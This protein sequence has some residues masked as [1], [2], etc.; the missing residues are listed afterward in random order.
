M[1]GK[2]LAATAERVEIANFF[3]Y[4]SSF[5][6]GIYVDAGDYNND[7]FADILTGPGVGG[8]SHVR[9]FSGKTALA[10]SAP[11]ELAGFF[12]FTQTTPDNPLFT[13]GVPASGVGGVAFSGTSA[14]GSRNILVGTGRGP[15]CR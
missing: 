13:P 12:A 1:D 7:G 10:G 4:D 3:A 11:V 8:G 5:R 6:G 15:R 9:V 2:R 14:N